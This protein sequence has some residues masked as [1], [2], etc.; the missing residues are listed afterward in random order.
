[1][2]LYYDPCALY[3]LCMCTKCCKPIKLTMKFITSSYEKYV[4]LLVL[5]RDDGM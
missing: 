4:N 5:L 3:E 2:L 1:M